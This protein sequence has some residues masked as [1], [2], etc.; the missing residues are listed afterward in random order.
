LASLYWGGSLV[1]GNIP[2][3]VLLHIPNTPMVVLSGF[4]SL[5]AGWVTAAVATYLLT[6]RCLRPLTGLAMRD[7]RSP[8]PST[9]GVVPRL[10]LTFAAVVAA[11]L[12]ALGLGGVTLN[13]Q[14][15][16]MSY[17]SLWAIGSLVLILGFL[18]IFVSARAVADPVDEVRG[19]FRRLREGD[20]DAVVV[21]SEP[22][23]IGE[24]Q[25]G[26]NDM[27]R[28]LREREQM[29]DVF[30]RL[31]GKDVA[32]H[33]IEHGSDLVNDSR[34]ATAMFV[35]IIGSTPLAESNSPRDYL[36]KLNSFFDVVVKVIEDTGGVV[37]QFQGDGAL[38]LFGAPNEQPD[39]AVRALRAAREL[40][41][42]LDC[43]AKTSGIEAVIGV[44]TG[45]VIAGHV[46]T[47]NRYEF[48]VVGDAVNEAKRL[49]EQAK[50]AETKVL[51]SDATIRSA[52]G[53]VGKWREAGETNLRGRS[54]PTI[55]Y[56][57]GSRSF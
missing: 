18:V 36:T 37:N 19:G 9:V 32:E 26:F 35:D 33:A 5:G 54:R 31:V 34:E 23:E 2:F 3:N 21:V 42:E 6:E 41:D 47:S 16:A 44:S 25:A 20:L 27:V 52:E 11:P 24:L 39:H 55:A 50:T 7:I 46:G 49:A 45:D 4:V 48:T 12:I 53:E 28:S 57:P 14:Q 22:G 15:R 56:T 1:W 17:P 43:F 38:C 10:L 40:R 30:V 13:A 29:R 51:V 8:R